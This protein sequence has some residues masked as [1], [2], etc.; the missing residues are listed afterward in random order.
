M[1]D[2]ADRAYPR[3]QRHHQRGDVPAGVRAGLGAGGGL[4]LLAGPRVGDGGVG[5]E[6]GLPVDPVDAH[7]G[8]HHQPATTAGREDRGPVGAGHP[9]QLLQQVLRDAARIQGRSGKLP[10]HATELGEQPGRLGVRLWSALAAGLPDP[11]QGAGGVQA[12]RGQ[13]QPLGGDGEVAELAEVPQRLVGV[14]AAEEPADRETGRGDREQGGTLGRAALQRRDG[15]RYGE[16]RQDRRRAHPAD[17]RLGRHLAG[18]ESDDHHLGEAAERGEDP[19][20]WRDHRRDAGD[21]EQGD[22]AQLGDIAGGDQGEDRDQREHDDA[23]RRR[24][25]MR[26]G[27]GGCRGGHLTDRSQSP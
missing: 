10:G 12:E 18:R 1:S 16:V 13:H 24:E 6:G 17:R 22:P 8:E 21:R 2:Q 26:A 25:W 7:L 3:D 11:L 20:A 9:A 15:Q 23:C 19:V 5:V 14:V 27:E 4:R